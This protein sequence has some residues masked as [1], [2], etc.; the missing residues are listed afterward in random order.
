MRRILVL[1]GGAL[2]VLCAIGC[3]G[4]PPP[5]DAQTDAVAS[6]RSARA[7][8]AE[9]NPRASYHLELARENFTRAQ[10]LIAVGD[11]Q[12]AERL[13]NRAQADADVA[14]ALTDE[15]IAAAHAQAL[16]TRIREMRERNM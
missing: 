6:I 1:C 14:I 5:H 13:L 7:L 15:G 3:G 8:G 9:R 12:R 2:L 16:R 10:N 4:A 11:M